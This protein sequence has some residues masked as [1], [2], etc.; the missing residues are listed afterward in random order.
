M[1]DVNKEV[2]TTKRILAS[3]LASGE[4]ELAG[5]EKHR[6][7]LTALPDSQYMVHYSAG[8]MFVVYRPATA[9]EGDSIRSAAQK[10]IGGIAKREF[11][12]DTGQAGFRIRGK[13][14]DV[15]I[16]NGS[17]APNC[18]IVPYE[19]TVTKFRMD[20]PDAEAETVAKTG[21]TADPW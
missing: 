20:C 6:D 15:S 18:A 17:T 9:D 4:N 19:T 3:D 12:E 16:S 21:R 7:V 13:G 11:S 10:V 8:Q 2:E 5:L 14:V 1:V